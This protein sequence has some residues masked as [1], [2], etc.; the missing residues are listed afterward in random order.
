MS[1]IIPRT[2]ARYLRFGEAAR[3]QLAGPAGLP[4]SRR[5]AR[6]SV[7]GGAGLGPR[8]RSGFADRYLLGWFAFRFRDADLQ[9]VG[10]AGRGDVGLGHAFRERQ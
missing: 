8:G 9:D 7:G 3:P 10:I 4:G 2:D 6:H 1:L 5:R